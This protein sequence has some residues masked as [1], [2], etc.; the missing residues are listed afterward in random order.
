MYFSNESDKIKTEVFQWFFTDKEAV[1]AEA[2]FIEL[3]KPIYNQIDVERKSINVKELEQYKTQRIYSTNR[4]TTKPNFKKLCQEYTILQDKMNANCTQQEYDEYRCRRDEILL[5]SDDLS[6][7]LSVLS[8]DRLTANGYNKQRLEKEYNNQ[9]IIARKK[10]EFL[11]FIAISVGSSYIVRE[12]VDNMQSYYDN[13]GIIKK[14]STPDLNL[15]F[16]YKKTTIN[17]TAAI[18]I[19]GMK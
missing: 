14:A 11:S 9:V 13:N 5:C 6:R 4:I 19:L 16:D 7:Y 17:G 18:K 1:E 12:I 10:D 2:K 8:Y 15:F 3:F